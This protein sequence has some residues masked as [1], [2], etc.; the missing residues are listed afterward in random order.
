M[1]SQLMQMIRW[2][3]GELTEEETVELF[4]KLIDSTIV[5]K[6]QG[7]YGRMAQALIDNGLCHYRVQEPS[8]EANLRE[9]LSRLR[10][11]DNTGQ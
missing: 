9:Q 5:W 3:E 10:H 11:P 8:N 7:M 4:Q 2:E 1:S 6:L